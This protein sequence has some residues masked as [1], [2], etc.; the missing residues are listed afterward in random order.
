MDKLIMALLLAAC[1]ALTAY[2]LRI[3]APV[4]TAL[5]QTEGAPVTLAQPTADA[6]HAAPVTE[7]A[8]GAEVNAGVFGDAQHEGMDHSNHGAAKPDEPAS[9][10]AF[11]KANEVMHR[12]MNIQF[13]GAADADFVRGMIPHHQGAID[14]AKVVLEHGK[15]PEI[16]KLAEGIVAAQEGE[17]KLMQEWLAKNGK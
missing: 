15:D 1:A 6:T 12:D 10:K 16:R 5:P 8:T 11:R 7:S 17:I 3:S 9:T 4:R 13:S 2:A 14:M